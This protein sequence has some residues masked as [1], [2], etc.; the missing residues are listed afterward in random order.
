MWLGKGSLNS[1]T[2]SIG[3]K[4]I[5]NLHYDYRCIFQSADEIML[6]NISLGNDE[7]VHIN[8]RCIRIFGCKSIKKTENVKIMRAIL[9]RLSYN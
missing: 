9:R 7:C 6:W 3:L 5:S 2:V 8:M 1:P 4:E